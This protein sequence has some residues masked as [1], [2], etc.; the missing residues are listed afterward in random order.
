MEDTNGYSDHWMEDTNLD[1]QVVGMDGKP[2][3]DLFNLFIIA[4]LR[5]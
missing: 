3:K 1:S 4:Y 2:D 5:F